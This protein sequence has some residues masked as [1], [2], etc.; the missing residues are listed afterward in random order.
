MNNIISA[1][2]AFISFVIIPC[3]AFADDVSVR[4]FPFCG[5]PFDKCGFI[6]M[7]GFERK[8]EV[9]PKN[10]EAGIEFSEGL[11]GVRIKGRWGF[12]DMQ[13]EIVISPQFDLVGSF[14]HGLAEVLIGDKVGVIDRTGKIIIKPQFAR[15]IPF[16]DNV[17]IAQP[18]EWRSSY[19]RG[20]EK[21]ENIK[22]STS[23][24]PGSYG[25][26]S[27]SSGWITKPEWKFTIFDQTEKI[28]LI[29]AKQNGIDAL[30][31]LMR[32][33][34][35]WQVE[36]RYDYVQS[37]ADDRAIV[38]EKEPLKLGQKEHAR[39]SVLG[40]VD[41]E[42]KLVVPLS[43]RNLS[44]WYNGF[45]L[46]RDLKTGK[47]G[48]IDKESSLVGGRYFEKVGRGT[49][50]V[51]EVMINGVWYGIDRQGN[52]V[53]D[54]MENK[55]FLACASG[56]KLVYKSRKL[57]LF[58]LDGK[59][60]AP[61]LFDS[62]YR[63]YDDTF[64]YGAD[65]NQ[66]NYVEYKGKHGLINRQGQLL[67]DPPEFD[68]I[69]SFR[70]GH[71]IIEKD[72]K[73]GIINENG[74]FTLIPRYDELHYT[75][76][77]IYKAKLAD[78]TIWI[79]A[80]GVEQP[81]P[82]K[83]AIDRSSYLSCK[84]GLKIISSDTKGTFW[85]IADE[86]G[87]IVISPRYRAIHCFMNGV[88]WVPIGL[89]RKWCP[90][91]PDGLFQDYPKCITSRYPDIHPHLYP[92]RFVSDHYENSVLWSRAFLAFGIGKRDEPPRMIRDRGN[93]GGSF[94]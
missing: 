15:A 52:I 90:I 33:D 69:S 60:T 55:V 21:L 4:Y 11:A 73:W 83:P 17:V 66:I 61:Y 86:K 77:S 3:N 39:K 18:G 8:E 24:G 79:D 40:A 70:N 65:C 75:W 71:A 48:L 94:R 30:Y 74:T 14:S 12:I 82:K 53:E 63:K 5:G 2:V 20:Y 1:F 25:L 62:V 47:E 76:N 78:K 54:P 87:N 28:S 81:E 72:K 36:P 89:K 32:P 34:G 7:E 57:Q 19:F 42:G 29:W 44:Y 58:G 92:E 22:D 27:V 91:N 67:F 6:R 88:A 51:G 56:F 9:I 31:G 68:N 16:S 93:G 84:G 13:G 80:Y 26:Y 35:S 59:P 10:F 41:P 50:G 45:A 64:Q 46:T 85:G 37:L 38:S 23:F 43:E 49:D